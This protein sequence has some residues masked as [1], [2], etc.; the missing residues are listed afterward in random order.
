MNVSSVIVPPKVPPRQRRGSDS[1]PCSPKLGS[2]L[3]K[4]QMTIGGVGVKPGSPKVEALRNDP[5]NPP[6]SLTSSSPP[7]PPPR[8]RFLKKGGQTQSCADI[9]QSCKKPNISKSISEEGST[10]SST[11]KDDMAM[12]RDEK[13]NQTSN[14]DKERKTKNFFVLEPNSSSLMTTIIN[15]DTKAVS[16]GIKNFDQT[17]EQK[18]PSSKEHL[19]RNNGEKENISKVHEKEKTVKT[20]IDIQSITQDEIISSNN[21]KKDNMKNEKDDTS[22]DKNKANTQDANLISREQKII[23]LEPK[24]EKLKENAGLDSKIIQQEENMTFKSNDDRDNAVEKIEIKSDCGA[25]S[26]PSIVINEEIDENESSKTS[27]KLVEKDTTIEN[28]KVKAKTT[29]KQ[30]PSSAIEVTSS[31][32]TNLKNDNKLNDKEKLDTRSVSN[33]ELKK[34]SEK[35][36]PPSSSNLTSKKQGMFD[37]VGNFSAISDK[38]PSVSS[39]TKSLTN[40]STNIEGVMGASKLSKV[41]KFDI[42]SKVKLL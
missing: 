31:D 33:N 30:R 10:N 24:E 17:D 29:S 1:A 13:E 19:D 36:L 21:E 26:K 38:L 7:K 6:P 5:F 9:M 12:T 40:A 35:V 41:V 3:K 4:R 18:V 32:K 8:G 39:V 27:D 15:E 2:P 16:N 42:S 37:V 34:T 28:D 22:S 20:N 23:E 25:K 14:D 11:S